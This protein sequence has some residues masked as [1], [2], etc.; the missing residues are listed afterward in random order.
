[1]RNVRSFPALTTAIFVDY[2]DLSNALRTR[3]GRSAHA[4]SV[5]ADALEA[6]LPMLQRQMNAQV[7]ALNA[8]ADFGAL[9]APRDLLRDLAA[10]GVRTVLTPESTQHNASELELTMDVM[11]LLAGRSELQRVVIVTGQRLYLPLLRRIKSEGRQVVLV[12]LESLRERAALLFDEQDRTISLYELAPDAARREEAEPAPPVRRDV[13]YTTVEDEGT[14]RAL[15]VIEE[16]FGQY[17]E[18]YLTPL[19]RKLSDEL[20]DESLDPKTLISDLEEAGAVY[21]EKRRG[22]PHDYTVLIVDG[23][24]PDVDRI[25]QMFED[26]DEEV[27]PAG[28]YTDDDAELALP[29]ED[30]EAYESAA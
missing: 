13:E 16:F 22:Y 20:D 1:M 6:L 27:Y 2:G 21:L 11:T 17:N 19:L 25:R 30:D 8:Y 4:D 3:L 7:V 28:P 23:N 9:D 24:H 10:L 12:S 14:L 18:V 15:E 29:T 5:I 26:Y